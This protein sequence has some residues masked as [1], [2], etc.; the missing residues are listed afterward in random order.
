MKITIIGAT[1]SI[2]AATSFHLAAEG[3]ATEILMI[4]G[5]RKAALGQHTMDLST[6]ASG[7]DVLIKSGTF[8]DMVGS[9]IV[10]NAAGVV[11]A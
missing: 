6:A 1:G 8:E 9:D 4:G 10:I 11:P 5:K 7:K 3:L 2:G